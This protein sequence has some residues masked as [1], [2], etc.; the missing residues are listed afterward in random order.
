MCCMHCDST[1]GQH[2]AALAKL[3][4]SISGA[5]SS[6]GPFRERVAGFKRGWCPEREGVGRWEPPEEESRGRQAHPS[7]G[8][9]LPCTVPAAS[10][11][12]RGLGHW[13]PLESEKCPSSTMM[14]RQV[15]SGLGISISSDASQSPQGPPGGKGLAAPGVTWLGPT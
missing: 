9:M 13:T 5:E 1:R 7:H 15:A 4:K 11:R 2:D 10:V 14:G 12:M 6:Q 8:L 3:K